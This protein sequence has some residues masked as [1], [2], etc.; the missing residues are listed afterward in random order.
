MW[1][2]LGAMAVEVDAIRAALDDPRAV[3]RLGYALTQGA[4]GATPVV[5]AQSG[6]GKVNAALAVTAL[7]DAGATRVVFTGMAGSLAPGVRCGDAVVATDL[8]QHDV[9]GSAF[10]DTPRGQIPGEPAAWDA[11]GELADALARAAG[12]F[13]ARVHRGRIASGDQFIAD[14]LAAAGI[15]ARCQALAVDMESA[16]AAQAAHTLGVPL[17]V[18][19]WISDTAD[20][21]APADFPAF[22]E[23]VADLD[24]A[25]VRGLLAPPATRASGAHGSPRRPK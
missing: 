13:G 24:L 17:A 23:R 11:D 5:V 18:L 16:A 4:L 20:E 6:I 3:R 14:R 12:G 9:D 21:G 10:A 7:V 1:G 22:C 19:R 15:A 25:I 2:V 8:V